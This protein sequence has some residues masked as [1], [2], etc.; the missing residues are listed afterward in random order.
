[1]ATSAS[2][3]AIILAAGRSRRMGAENKLLA[4]LGGAPLV[5]RT[6]ANAA[7]SQARPLIVVTG[8][9]ADEVGAAI[10]AAAATIVHN[11]GFADGM[12][13]SLQ[14]GLAAVPPEADGALIL[15]GDMPL[16]SPTMIDRLIGEAQARPDA[17]AAV[18]TVGGEWAHPV[19]LRRRL[20]A[21]VAALGGDAGARRLLSQRADILT[22]AVDDPRCLMDADDPAALAAIRARFEADRRA[23]PGA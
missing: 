3:A 15:L 22:V 9:M 6:L 2:F 11:R 17:P 10:G 12:A 4:D 14:A 19:L 7:A 16:I 23:Q 21:D 20:F 18:L 13:S 1:M 5:A 8:H